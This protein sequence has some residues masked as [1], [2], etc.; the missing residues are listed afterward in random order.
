MDEEDSAT[1]VSDTSS[2]PS[3]EFPDGAALVVEDEVVVIADE[4]DI[5]D[6]PNMGAGEP[7]PDPDADPEPESSFQSVRANL[8]RDATEVARSS[9]P[10]PEA[11]C[12][13]C[14][15]GWTNYG[16]HRLC[17]LKCGHLFGESCIVEW[18]EMSKRKK[19]KTFCPTCRK[20]AKVSDVRRIFATSLIAVDSTI[21][22]KAV[23]E[24]NSLRKEVEILVA[25]NTKLR[26]ERE[27]LLKELSTWRSP[28]ITLRETVI[29]SP[30]GNARVLAYDGLK[31]R[32]FGASSG[33]GFEV[34]DLESHAGKDFW[35]LHT[36]PIR[37]CKI[38]PSQHMILSA[39][40]DKTL[41]LSSLETSI[42][43]QRISLTSKAW[44]CAFDS[45][46]ENYFYAGLDNLNIHMFDLRNSAAAV[47]TWSFEEMGR[48]GMPIHSLHHVEGYNMLLGSSLK[49]PFVIDTGEQGKC[50]FSGDDF[51]CFPEE[52]RGISCT[53]ITYNPKFQTFLS[54]WR[55]KEKRTRFTAGT[56]AI[57][58]NVPSFTLKHDF[59]GSEQKSM[60]RSKVISFR[61]Q[62]AFAVGDE[63][64]PGITIYTARER[65][66]IE[67]VKDI[68]IDPKSTVMDCVDMGENL[69]VL[70]ES[71]LYIYKVASPSM[72]FGPS[73]ELKGAAKANADDDVIVL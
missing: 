73:I 26:L 23:Q 4:E 22:D 3:D 9:D 51:R 43:F 19:A 35:S 34:L 30:Q 40:T 46:S 65:G 7:E 31:N 63:I 37:D 39:S 72:D 27:K 15:E 68:T 14:S 69:G 47:K 28:P 29:I 38:S 58:Q 6:Q 36:A 60:S 56:I 10:E 70:S 24:K 61:D 42:V 45:A 67:K 17:S 59:N 16:R 48:P 8:K 53:S 71:K 49:A 62:M 32:V 11:E 64:L 2:D 55:T 57:Q 66:F 1:E 41:C 50:I 54:C 25:D 20:A 18:L 52:S 33:F 21:L 13:I 12:T 5:V 44:S